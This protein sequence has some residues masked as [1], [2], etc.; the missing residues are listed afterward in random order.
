MN[1]V[2][3]SADSWV[4]LSADVL[5]A[6]LLVWVA[7]MG[8]DAELTP[9][10][11]WFFFDRYQR[12]AQ[13]HRVRGRVAKAQRL[14]VKADDHYHAGG[15]DG[16]PHA[17]AVAMPRPDRFIRTDAVSRHQPSDYDDAA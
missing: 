2:T 9:E 16:P 7:S 8:R 15:G 13:Y 3:A 6:R 10:A 1:A 11:H 12:L 17:A 5:S 4:W 14:Q